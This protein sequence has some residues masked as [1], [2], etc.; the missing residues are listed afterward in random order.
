M[1]NI[2]KNDFV[3]V[4]DLDDTLY[5]E[6]DYQT[7]GIKA[8]AKEIL[9]LYGQDIEDEM[10][11]WRHQGEKDVFGRACKCLR[12]PE[13]I[14][15]SFLWVYR[16]HTP[17]IIFDS[18][19]AYTLKKLKKTV[20]ELLVLTDGRSVS[21]R[22]KMHA[23]GLEDISVYIS[24][25]YDSEKPEKK[26]F[27]LIMHEHPAAQYCY[28]GDNPAKDFIAPNNL[29]WLT[30]GIRC[31]LKNIHSQ[32]MQGLSEAAMPNFWIDSL[33]ELFDLLSNNK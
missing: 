33:F 1:A 19:V 18:D 16:L 2:E 20:R 21:Q 24:E 5:A 11:R 6:Y 23:L 29:G 13:S 27:D 14:K 28:I 15:E 8:V 12:L 9:M 7:S 4:F 3:V 10:L 25:E 31:T 26:R 22:K 17:Q 30:V 32:N